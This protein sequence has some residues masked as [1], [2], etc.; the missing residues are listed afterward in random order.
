VC[1][2]LLLRS[3]EPNDAAPWVRS[4]SERCRASDEYQGHGWGFASWVNGAWQHSRSIRPIW[5]ET[6]EL[7][8]SRLTLVH[9]RSA[10]RNEGIVVENNMPFVDGGLAFAF[11]GEIRGVKLAAPGATGAAKLLSLFTRF[12]DVGGGDSGAALD[13]LNTVVTRRSEHVRALNVMVSDG[14]SVWTNSHFAA[15]EAA[16]FTLH[17]ARM[18]D[19]AGGLTVVSSERLDVPDFSPAWTPLPNHSLVTHSEESPCLS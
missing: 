12:R 7:P 17:E 2:L 13:R 3:A 4:F 15:D 18:P 9:A 5:E 14:R 1:R 8:P 10:F 19:V 6:H 11:N 16:Y